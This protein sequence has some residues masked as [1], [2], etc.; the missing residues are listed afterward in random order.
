MWPFY[1]ENIN[2]RERR[3]SLTPINKDCYNSGEGLGLTATGRIWR[4]G[5]TVSGKDAQ[6][7]F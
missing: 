6:A 1:D 7:G 3:K 4:Y 5:A 2:H